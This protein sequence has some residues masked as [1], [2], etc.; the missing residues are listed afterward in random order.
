MPKKYDLLIRAYFDPFSKQD[1]KLFTGEVTILLDLKS[2]TSKIEL[3]VDRN[4]K[5][6]DQNL[7]L[8]NTQNGQN[9][10]IENH[11]F[12]PNQLYQILTKN[13]LQPGEYRLTIKF[14]GY[15]RQNGFYKTEYTENGAPRTLLATRFQPIYARTAL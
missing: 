7:I 12:V 6:T 2:A 9:V 13:Q 14:E 1:Q 11:R 5:I 4:L 8:Q 15:T 10:Q 3:H